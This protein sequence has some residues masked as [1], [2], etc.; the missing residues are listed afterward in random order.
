MRPDAQ[1]D[2]PTETSPTDTPQDAEPDTL[3]D[4]LVRIAYLVMGVLTRIGAENDMSLTQ[5]RVL[6]ILRDR[7]GRVTE[8][9]THLG[10][11]KSTMSGLVDRAE[12]RGLLARGKNPED[13]RGVD[14]FA[15][16]AGLELARR[17]REEFRRALAPSTER[18]TPEQRDQLTR[19]LECLL[20]E[21]HRAPAEPGRAR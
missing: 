7:R 18:L 21:P 8:L 17:L 3:E 15:T 5:L 11:D 19:L 12:R 4:A 20:D 6:G 10:L 13:G 14:V 1:A 2:A 9:A 16:P